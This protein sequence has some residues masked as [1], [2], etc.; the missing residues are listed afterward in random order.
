M[1]TNA[2]NNGV[3][4]PQVGLG[5]Y[6][7]EPDDAQT[8]VTYAL[9]N[10]YTLIDTANVYVNERAVGRGMRASSKS[11]DQIF[12]ETKLWPSFFERDTEVDETL[13]RL[14]VGS[15][16]LMILHQPAGN[17]IAGYRQLEAAYKAGKIRAIGLSN[18]DVKQ[19][20][21]ILDECEV[22]PAIN[23]V[24]CHPY[25]PQTELKALLNEHDIALQ[26]WFPLGGR[27]NDSIMGEALIQAIAGKHGKSP[28]QVILRWHVQQG[29]IVIP[30]SKTP[31]HIAQNIELFDFALTDEEM[32]QIAT[33]DRGKP[34]FEHT[35]ER[36][37]QFAAFVP[38]VEGQK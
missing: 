12:L 17:I 29:H 19:T 9:D 25:F 37:A 24:E 38:D 8:A 2:L 26:T 36:L 10:G 7:L 30:G 32:A 4:I 3:E 27:G 22:V 28:A 21:R 15:I 5:T 6:V 16:D 33:L 31:S 11:H 23:Q 18:F 1:E 35:E 13:E 14:G 34:M 20:Q